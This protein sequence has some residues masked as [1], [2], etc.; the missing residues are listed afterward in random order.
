[1]ELIEK[2]LRIAA[3]AH[4]DQVRKD[5]QSPYIVHPIM[6]GRIL[7]QYGFSESVV[8]AGLVHDVLEDSDISETTLHDE[9]GAEVVAIVTAV[10]EDTSLEWE[11][12]KAAYVESVAAASEAIK[13]VSVADKIHNARSLL[14][15]HARDG[16]AVWTVFNRG[17]EKKLWFERMLCD[18]LRES[19]QHPLLDEYDKLVT[20]LEALD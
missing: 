18:R 20:Q 2:A 16:V 10:S 6:V 11:D 9:L 13:A 19:W 14:A 5:D 3:T 12:R 17:K 15:G 4:K 1:M 7:E 8:A